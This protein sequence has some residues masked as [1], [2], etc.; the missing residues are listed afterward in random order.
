MPGTGRQSLKSSMRWLRSWLL[1]LIA[2]VSCWSPQ[3]FATIDDSSVFD[4]EAGPLSDALIE[5]SRQSGLYIV[6]SDKLTR[7]WQVDAVVGKQTNK[8]ALETLLDQS[9]LD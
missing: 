8:R 6:F 7:H 1:L 3:T 5:F 9:G 2:S 4:I